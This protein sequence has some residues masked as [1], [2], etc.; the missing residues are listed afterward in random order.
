MQEYLSR[1]LDN[2]SFN[3]FHFDRITAGD[4]NSHYA[5]SDYS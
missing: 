3:V 2:W 5:H 4:N 1:S